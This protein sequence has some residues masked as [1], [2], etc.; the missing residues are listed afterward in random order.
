MFH[1]AA[2]CLNI[3]EIGNPQIARFGITKNVSN[4]EGID[5]NISNLYPHPKFT[6]KTR[7][8]NNDIALLKLS[9]SV[10]INE[11]ILPICLPTESKSYEK[12][13][14]SG[15]GKTENNKLSEKLL[16]VT[17]DEI[18]H[19][20]CRL[21]WKGFFIGNYSMLCYGH[22]DQKK[23]SCSVSPFTNLQI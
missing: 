5:F 7:V 17:L 10:N 12:A 20:A 23:D 1:L 14:V 4:A 19:E 22:Q 3:S 2:H 11:K 9:E 6:R 15:F 8:V 16:K 18:N 13:I 21:K